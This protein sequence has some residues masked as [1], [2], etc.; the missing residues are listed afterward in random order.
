MTRH[1]QEDDFSSG[2][3]ARQWY[4]KFS[5]T[6]RTMAQALGLKRLQELIQVWLHVLLA[7][8]MADVSC[9]TTE[10]LHACRERLPSPPGLRGC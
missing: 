4:F 8:A 7:P 9:A 10:L 5:Q 6:W 2:V 1:A 3:V